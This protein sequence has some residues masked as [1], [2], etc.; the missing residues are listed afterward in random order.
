MTPAARV[1]ATIQILQELETTAQP[2]DRF[3]RDWFRRRRY[4]GSKDRAA[5]AERVFDVLR[6]RSAFAWRT[7]SD[8]PR[9]LAIASL[10]HEGRKA[11]DIRSLFGAE[12]YGPPPLTEEEGRAV[13]LPPTGEPPPHVQGEYPPWL[14]PELQRAFSGRLL[15]EMRALQS[16]A[17]IDL[18]VNT[19][20]ASRNDVLRQLCEQGF[21][22]EVTPY[23][24]LAIRVPAGARGLDKTPAFASGAFE[25]QDEASQIAALLG[26]AKPGM[27]VLDLAAGAGGKS[28][29]MAAQM[30]NAGEILA[31]DDNPARMTPLAER[32]G[33]AGATCITVAEKRGGP[34]W[35]N[36]EFDRVLVDAPCSGTGTW[37]RQPELRWRLAPERLEALRNA[38]A[39]LLA[40]GARHLKPCGRLIYATCSLLPSENEDQIAAFFEHHSDFAILP[41]RDAWAE[42]IGTEPP[43]GMDEFFRATPLT[44][45]TDGFFT[46]VLERAA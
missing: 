35:G 31:F 37:R 32:A 18:R 10:L 20:R 12:G 7:Q 13:S 34:K 23:S 30:Q 15:D 29:A 43:P 46:A 1:Q 2:A 24:P 17:P 22:A 3:L 21:D 25:V 14:E 27:R 6:H 41:A 19:L 8:T 16:R 26:D 38:Q 28:L 9:A 45:G 36:G 40:E 33:R 11:E 4:A 42:S 39:Q 5:V 44:T